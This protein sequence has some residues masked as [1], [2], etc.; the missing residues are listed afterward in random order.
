MSPNTS[1][2]YLVLLVTYCLLHITVSD[3]WFPNAHTVVYPKFYSSPIRSKRNVDVYHNDLNITVMEL[4][5]WT[6]E[7]EKNNGLHFSENFAFEFID[8]DNK[9]SVIKEMPECNYLLGE[10]RGIKSRSVVTL[11]A[12]QVTGF[13]NIGNEFYFVQPTEENNTNAHILFRSDLLNKKRTKRQS[14][15]SVCFTTEFYN[16]TG[17]VEELDDGILIESGDDESDGNGRNADITS[18]SK[19]LATDLRSQI[20]PEEMGYFFDSTWE[21]HVFKSMFI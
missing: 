13:I 1:H 7:Y 5:D 19:K 14:L 9:T 18:Y 4:A 8:D 20:D 12:N 10:I 16:L 15:G 3:D 6:V 2:Y 21:M 17:D 11:C